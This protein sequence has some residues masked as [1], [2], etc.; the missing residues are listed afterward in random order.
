MKW[1]ALFA[2]MCSVLAAKKI[3]TAHRH[4]AATKKQLSFCI[5]LTE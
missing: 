2:I 3:I 4:Q 1:I 5:K